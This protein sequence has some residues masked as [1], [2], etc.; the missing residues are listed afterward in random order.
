MMILCAL[1][2]ITILIVGIIHLDWSY[3]KTCFEL[4]VTIIFVLLYVLLSKKLNLKEMQNDNVERRKHLEHISNIFDN[5]NGFVFVVDEN[6]MIVDMNKYAE[7]ILQY[8]KEE[9]INSNILGLFSKKVHSLVTKLISETKSVSEVTLS[10]FKKSGRTT[11]ISFNSIIRNLGDR[12][13]CYIFASRKDNKNEKNKVWEKNFKYY[14]ELIP[15]G[16]AISSRTKKWLQ[17]NKTLQDMLG[18][19][20]QEL[21]NITW[22]EITHPEDSHDENNK[23][24]QMLDGNISEYHIKK[25]FIRKD[26]QNVYTLLHVKGISESIKSIKYVLMVLQDIAEINETRQILNKKLK[27]EKGFANCSRILL[28]EDIPPEQA[29]KETLKVLLSTFAIRRIFVYENYNEKNEKLCSRLVYEVCAQ[30]INSELVNQKREHIIYDCGFDRWKILMLQNQV[31]KSRYEE[32]PQSEQKFFKSWKIES[33]LAI[34]LYIKSKWIGFIGFENV[35][36]KEDWNNSEIAMLHTISDMIVAY[37]GRKKTENELEN[38]K[39]MLTKRVADRT[40]ELSGAN[41]QLAQ[42]AKLKDEF[43]ASMSHELR[44]PLNAILGLSEALVDQVYGP[45]NED[46]I[47]TLHTVGKSGRHLL[48][49]INDILDLSKIGAGNLKLELND[50]NIYSVCEMSLRCVKQQSNNKQIE[51]ETKY[52]NNV[53]LLRVDERRLKQILVNLLSNA[54]KFSPEKG[55][56]NLTTESDEENQVVRFIV[57]DS[58]IGIEENGMAN[59]FKPFVQHDS[60]LSRKHGGTGLG[61]SLVQKLVEMHGG[62]ITVESQVSKGSTFIVSLPWQK[63]HE[64]PDADIQS[65]NDTI[66]LE[67]IGGIVVHTKNNTTIH[68]L[69]KYFKQWNI[70]EINFISAENELYPALTSNP[71]FLFLDLEMNEAEL[72]MWLNEISIDLETRDI[73]TIIITE[74]GLDIKKTRYDKI[75]NILKP[76]NQELIINSIKKLTQGE[77]EYHESNSLSGANTM[78]PNHQLVIMLVED[79]EYNINMIYDYLSAKKYLVIVARNGKE[80]IKL[81]HECTPDLILMDIQMPEMDGIEAMEI[82][83]RNESFSKIPIVALT[84][85]AMPGDRERCLLAGANDYLTKPVSLKI[86][87][88][89]IDKYISKRENVYE[90]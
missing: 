26:G 62:S 51:I 77:A 5:Y 15:L 20:E 25:R 22:S 27:Y 33:I 52:D 64:S 39:A 68:K 59:L 24:L 2:S 67:N 21:L 35:L 54:I 58:G 50:A 82:I 12:N 69:N 66:K 18:Y 45:L 44:T 88:K 53:K 37:I 3:P 1:S 23:F 8:T 60:S 90:T 9:L 78:H 84:A 43:I 14:F 57:S 87:I 71:N 28:R 11:S 80:A 75:L 40:K 48:E 46:H 63:C 13:I 29:I 16:M 47:K 83:R 72:C 30:S 6:N 79:N 17:V 34:P 36:L 61:L 65:D 70:N 19:S 10:I 56:I 49:L 76:I 32:L 7:N 31:I 86:L 85:L 73:K 38:E 89:T 81:L 55:I 74:S 42:A 4:S 41:A